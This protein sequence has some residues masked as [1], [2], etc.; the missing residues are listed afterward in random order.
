MNAGALLRTVLVAVVTASVVAAGAGPA[1]FAGVGALSNAT[2]TAETPNPAGAS[3]SAAALA[4]E[5][6][7][8][9][10]RPNLEL[11]APDNQYGAGE[12]VA[13]EVYISNDGDI[14]RGGPSEYE[15]RVTTARNVRLDIDEDRL[16]DT[17]ARAI[18][19]NSGTVFA[20]SVP[21]GVSG[22]YAFN[23]EIGDSLSPG[24]YRIPVEVSYDYTNF[25]RYRTG[26]Q[27][28][29]GDLSREQTAY[30]TI[31]VEDQPRFEISSQSLQPVTPGE[32][33][34]YRMN[35][36]NTGTQPAV[37]ADV[38]L[39]AA[40]SSLFFGNAANPQQQTSVFFDRIEPGETKTFNV[41]VGATA[42]TA[43]GTYIA[44][45]MV[46]YEQPNGVAGRSELL[47]YGVAVGGEQTFAI[48]GVESNLTVGDSGLV[49][50]TVVNTGETNVTDAVVTLQPGN[51]NLQ[52][53]ETEYAV[54]TLAPGESANFSFRID[55][56]NAA[57][58]GPRRVS[59]QVRYANRQGDTRTGESVDAIV[60]VDGEQTFSVR[61]VSGDLQVGDTGTVSG[62]LVNTG[63]QTVSNA[64]VVFGTG[65][66][67]FQPRETQIAVGTLT[68]GE[69]VP[70]EFTV[71]V[72]NGSEPGSRQVSFQ[73]RYR[74]RND[75][76]R[77]SDA[78]E[79]RVAV[80]GEQTFAV[81]NLNGTLRVGQTGDLTGTI[82]NTGNRTVSNAVV[83][84]RTNNPNL[85][86]R[87]TEY[88]VGTLAPGESASFEYTVDV[89]TEAEPGPRQLSFR[90]RYR[91]QNND[92]RTS[93]PIDGRVTVAEE[94]DEFRVEPV[95]A[96]VPAGGAEVVA[97]RVT[98]T[99]GETLRN[100]DAKLFA[101]DPLSSDNDEAFVDRLAPG[102]STVLKFRV[103]AA[104]S[105]IP[106]DYP[107]S[108]DF[109]Y[110]NERGDDVLSETY[111]VPIEVVEPRRRGFPV[112]LDAGAAA[113]V[114][115]GAAAVVA[116][117]LGWWKRDALAQL[118]P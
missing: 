22:P 115:G 74:N 97:V 61:G 93:E 8:V 42:D 39:S 94:R 1:A 89:N 30:V 105:A 53:R 109:A 17:L 100:V 62:T 60:A 84:L 19:I 66:S 9:V 90:V 36:T 77:T 29:Y 28:E 14:D 37:R 43:P 111:R 34:T 110:E 27:P 92:L 102:E 80:G 13:L 12:Q 86:P 26:G 64:V 101:S 56:A 46:A 112:V 113:W 24:T 20:G 51:P 81:R 69:S 45:A 58:P 85:D 104:G 63:N 55:T 21:E 38:T 15:Q 96:T 117:G 18:D 91:N 106:K 31:V 107:V 11:T 78:L 82:V 98:N 5:E 44:N 99:A 72:P 103:S 87:E 3:G 73:V 35:L 52:P 79:S 6:G 67:N 2:G 7:T 50:G 40:N 33:A 71:D 68:P 57:D 49:T 116:L 10:G 4:Q 59:F 48:R 25:V 70:F 41:T 23:L 75:E 95:N 47:R 16:N 76:L 108:I 88:A 114:A 83:D 32:T 65:N 118:L 54:G